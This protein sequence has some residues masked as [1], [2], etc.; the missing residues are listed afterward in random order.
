VEAV[1]GFCGLKS[2]SMAMQNV[3]F[4]G[5]VHGYV[6]FVFSELRASYPLHV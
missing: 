5:T 2:E 6:V 1:L 4:W 3:R